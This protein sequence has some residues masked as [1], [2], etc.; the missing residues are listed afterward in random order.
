MNTVGERLKTLREGMKFSQKKMAELLNVTQPSINRYEHG[1]SVPSIE[2]LIKYADYFDVS[3][4]YITCRCD[5][6]QGKLYQVKPPVADN[7]ELAKFVEMCFEP[8]SP[9]N[10]QLKKTLIQMLGTVKA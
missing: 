3:M 5:E 2:L 10:E 4:D 1:Q 7:P 6:P 8:D 9:M